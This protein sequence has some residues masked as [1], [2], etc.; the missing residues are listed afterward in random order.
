M[1]HIFVQIQL[2]MHY[3]TSKN[4]SFHYTFIKLPFL[5]IYFCLLFVCVFDLIRYGVSHGEILDADGVGGGELA[6]RLAIG[7]TQIIQENKEYFTSHGVNIDALESTL[8][9][10]KSQSNQKSINNVIERSNPT[11]KKFTTRYKFRRVRRNVCKVVS[12][13]VLIL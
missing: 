2:L 1:H 11:D 13:N 4:N 5:F 10:S 6:V 9:N 12:F 3:Q 8:I 7:E